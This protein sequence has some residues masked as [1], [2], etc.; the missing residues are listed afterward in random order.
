MRGR[1]IIKAVGA[2]LLMTPSLAGAATLAASKP[3][4]R[5]LAAEE[6][7]LAAM[8]YRMATANSD[9]CVSPKMTTGLIVH[10]LSQ[11]H[12]S[13]RGDVARAF[14][15]GAGFGV[16]QVVD[17]SAA[18]RAGLRIDDEILGVGPISVVDPSLSSR[19]QSFQRV[20]GFADILQAQLS[21]GPAELRVRRN[22]QLTSVVLTGERGCGGELSLSHSGSRNAWADGRHIV[23]TTAMTDFAAS[24]D[25]IAFV[26]A[27]EMAHN[28]LNHS[29]AGSKSGFF[30]RLNSRKLEL[31]ADN[32]GVSIMARAGYEP[33]AGISFLERSQKR[34]WWGG[35]SLSHPSFGK[36]LQKVAEAIWNWQSESSRN[37]EAHLSPAPAKIH[38]ASMDESLRAASIR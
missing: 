5:A 22:G 18:S 4:V 26:I 25:E 32:L 2:A 17:G 7:R 14:S 1:T 23:V 38:I 11:Y 15:L 31:D 30:G 36:R 13:R 16:L 28:I 33:R 3:T 29:H 24:D 21:K 34:M 9:L 37:Q 27:H 6:A 20:Q 12:P 35:L 10:D 8:A 19:G